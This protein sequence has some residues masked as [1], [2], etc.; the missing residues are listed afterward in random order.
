MVLAEA[1]KEVCQLVNSIAPVRSRF[2]R[3]WRFTDDEEPD[4]APIV[5]NFFFFSIT[6]SPRVAR[7]TSTRALHLHRRYVHHNGF[8]S[9]NKRLTQLGGDVELYINVC[10]LLSCCCG[11]RQ[12]ERWGVGRR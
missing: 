6:H 9:E 8:V 10:N 2:M 5:E 11:N 4:A 3:S 1:A 12:N 7:R